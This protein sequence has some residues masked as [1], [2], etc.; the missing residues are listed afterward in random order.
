MQSGEARGLT[1][2]RAML[3]ANRQQDLKD[4]GSVLHPLELGK[5]ILC[6]FSEASREIQPTFPLQWLAPLHTLV[7]IS[8]FTM[9]LFPSSG[10]LE[11]LPQ[12][13]ALVSQILLWTGGEA[14]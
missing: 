5:L 1:P 13:K 8:S 2:Y 11:S 12:V 9:L 4:K 10:S 6:G 14:G 3:R 7:L